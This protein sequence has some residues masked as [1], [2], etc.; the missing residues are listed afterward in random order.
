MK[1]LLAALLVVLMAVSFAACGGGSDEPE[2]ETYD[3]NGFSIQMEKGM[4]IDEMEGFE[5]FATSDNCMIT[6][7]REDFDIFA[8][9]GY[10]PETMTI[11]EYADLVAMA[12]SQFGSNFSV[13]ANG[14]QAVTYTSTVDGTTFYYH[15]TVVKGSDA[16]W[17]ITLCCFEEA[18]AEYADQFEAWVDTIVVE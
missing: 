13:D 7:V 6:G 1:K 12:N 18:Q 9:Y 8:S 17:V 4:E 2:L 14:N 3:F 16:F 15:A 11:E 10:D 5:A